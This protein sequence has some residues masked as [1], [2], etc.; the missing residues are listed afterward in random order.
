VHPNPIRLRAP[1]VVIAASLL[2]LVPAALG[3]PAIYSNGN[4]DPN[5]P[6]LAT[7][8]LTGSGAAAPLG[9]QWSEAASDGAASANA[10]GGF[11]SH[12]SGTTGAF[13]FADD[14]TVT[15]QGGWQLLSVSLYAYQSGAGVSVS[16]FSGV[17][18]RIW[19]GRPGDA[20]SSVVFGDTTTN[21]MVASTF[22]DT[23]RVFSTTVAPAAPADTTRAI[24]QT[25]VNLD[26]TVLLPGTY[27]LDWQYTTVNPNTEAFTPPVTVPGSRTLAGW[28][29]RQL[30]LLSGSAAW[31]DLV[32]SG[33]P[34]TVAN[35]AQDLP[36]I[37]RGFTSPFPCSADFDGDGDTGTDLDIENFFACLG[38]ACCPTC[39][40][41]DFNGDGDTGTDLDI[42]S[43]FRVLAGGPC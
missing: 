35:V 25:E 15:A 23:Y 11:S 33:K 17:N 36:F 12:A 29:A 43:F 21:R 20:F 39:G 19:N 13:R 8:A 38:G 22:T 5:A 32:D 26:S 42:E 2:G 40:S 28:N 1:S 14:F 41:A 3:Q 31:A 18:V 34:V 16:P 27:W 9:A 4:T 37:I 6:G 10:V 24:W 7:G 30:K